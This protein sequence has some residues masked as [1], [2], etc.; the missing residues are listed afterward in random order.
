MSL[1]EKASNVLR[2]MFEA[3]PL[4]HNLEHVE[5]YSTWRDVVGAEVARHTRVGGVKGN[6]LRVEVDSSPWLYELSGFRKN[7]LLAALRK[8][9]K[10]TRIIDIDFR[11]GKF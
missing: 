2:R 7:Q 10:K 8:A 9:L 5:I 4:G 3:S 1:P 6:V 11:I